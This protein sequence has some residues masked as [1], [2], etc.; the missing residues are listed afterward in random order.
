MLTAF[1]EDCVTLFSAAL[2]IWIMRSSMLVRSRGFIAATE[3][4]EYTMI[5]GSFDGDSLCRRRQIY[6]LQYGFTYSVVETPKG[7]Q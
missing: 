1:A 2:V 5:W 4:N 3:Q 7:R 6:D